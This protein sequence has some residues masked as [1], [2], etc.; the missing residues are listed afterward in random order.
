MYNIIYLYNGYNNNCFIINCNI[1]LYCKITYGECI[2]TLTKNV[3][4][5][6]YYFI[7]RHSNH[8]IKTILRL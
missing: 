7:H 5:D 6:S 3:R 8:E 2:V 1:L 4:N